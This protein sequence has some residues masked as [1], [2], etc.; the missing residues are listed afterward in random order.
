VRQQNVTVSGRRV[1]RKVYSSCSCL[2]NQDVNITAPWWTEAEDGKVADL[3]SPVIVA[4]SGRQG[5]DQA[6]DGYCPFDCGRQFSIL[7]GL[8]STFSLLGSTG[9][10]GNQLLSLRAVEPRDKAAG[11]IIM[12]R[13]LWSG[14]TLSRTSCKNITDARELHCIVLN[15]WPHLCAILVKK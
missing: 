6:I 10:I 7:I 8:L 12:V 15:L 13:Y 1:E 11:L 2:Q 14:V 5:L 4:K 9:R 3:E